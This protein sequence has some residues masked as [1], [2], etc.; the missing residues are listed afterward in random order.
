M[1]GV[2]EL[3]RGNLPLLL[4]GVAAIG[5]L[6]G[7]VHIF[8]FSLGSAAVLFAGLAVGALDPRLKLPD[9]V[10]QLGLVIFVYTVALSSGPGFRRTFSR[11]G[12]RDNLF[13][14][15]MVVFAAALTVALYAIFRI[16]PTHAA[17]LFAGSLTN[18]PA[19]AAI[20]ESLQLHPP[21]AVDQALS[22]PVFA[23]SIAYPFGVVGLM[24]AMYLAR[25]IWKVDFAQEVRTRQELAAAARELTSITVEIANPRVEGQTLHDLTREQGWRVLFGRVKRGGQ[26]MIYTPEIRAQVGDWVTVVGD[27]RET[28][29][30][31]Q[32]L[33]HRAREEADLDHSVLDFRR[34]FVSNRHVAGRTLSGLKLPQRFGGI[35][36]RVRRGDIDFLPNGDTVLELGDRVRVLA[37]RER[38]DEITKYFGDSYKTLSEIDVISFGIGIAAGLLLGSIAVPLPGGGALKLGLAGGPLVVGLFLG[39]RGRSG[40]FIWQLPY[41]ANLTLRQLGLVLFLAGIGTRAGEA[42]GQS[43]RQGEGLLLLLPGAVITFAT[44]FATLWIGYKL[45][46]IPMTVLYGMV[47]GVHTQAAAL[48]FANEQTKQDFPNLGY[49]TVYPVAMVAK[50][51]IAPL[52]LLLAG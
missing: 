8:G 27:N 50:I 3:L 18:T 21:G 6:V 4:F 14:L 30:V 11:R 23:Y 15:A 16:S 29:R 47:C 48:A 32:A 2:I 35:V 17:G 37:P 31:V 28:A 34:I 36:T 26:T 12:L 5:F 22:E 51:V 38:M 25:R 13:A 46:K 41:S 9:L 40:P 52:F 43:L 24:L 19:L 39:M 7:R 10:Y 44:A 33:G 45:F 42:F 49:A 1:Q 20:M